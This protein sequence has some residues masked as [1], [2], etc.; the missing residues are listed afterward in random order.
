MLDYLNEEHR[1]L[2]RLLRALC[3]AGEYLSGGMP[4]DIELFGRGI[5]LLQKYAEDTHQKYEEEIL[6]PLLESEGVTHRGGP[7]EVL[8]AE[9]QQARKYMDE[10]MRNLER[11]RCGEEDAKD[12]L[13]VAIK[14]YSLLLK[15]HI[16]KEDM[17]IF[18]LARHAFDTQA[19]SE[20]RK[21]GDE[22]RKTKEEK[23]VFEDFL[24]IAAQM[25]MD[26]GLHVSENNEQHRINHEGPDHLAEEFLQRNT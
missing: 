14:S 25:E 17:V 23:K 11:V 16:G 24:Q 8:L 12:E 5:D 13:V 1:A 9:H 6:F 22:A 4:V 20:I 2:E 18:P 19:T 15:A 26:L 21:I 10:I 7:L 3:T